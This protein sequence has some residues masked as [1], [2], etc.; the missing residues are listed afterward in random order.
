MDSARLVGSS[1]VRLATAI[2]AGVSLAT[3]L[4]L[5]G[6]G[7]AG[8]RSVLLAL[9]IGTGILAFLGLVHSFRLLHTAW[10]AYARVMHVLAVTV[11]FGACYLL[12]VPVFWLILRPF[13]PL[14]LRRRSRGNTFWIPRREEFDPTSLQRMG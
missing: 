5:R 12:I 10:L 6:N 14:R 8:M 3:G 4:A 7:F 11:L 2:L 9:T 13:D 1:L